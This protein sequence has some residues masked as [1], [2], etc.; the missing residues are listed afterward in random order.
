M[1][2]IRGDPAGIVLTNIEGVGVKRP[3]HQYYYL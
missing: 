3:F 1:C 2:T